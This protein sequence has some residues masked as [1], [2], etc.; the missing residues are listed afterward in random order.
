MGERTRILVVD[1]DESI[2]KTISTILEENGYKVDTAEDG[3]EA[4]EK[5]DARF[6]N[7]AL[8]DIKLPDMEGTE[9]LDKMRDTTP[10]MVKIIVTGFPSLR[11]AVEAVNKSADAYLIKPVKI[12]E[13][14]ETIRVHLEIQEEEKH[15]NEQKI[16]EFLETRLL[17][18][19]EIAT[20]KIRK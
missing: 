12:E 19:K 20:C 6:Y 14:L 16:A 15:Y 11:N 17:E 2:R 8:I 9:L 1:D 7:L 4:I 5:T 3:R 18:Q 13:L 10:R